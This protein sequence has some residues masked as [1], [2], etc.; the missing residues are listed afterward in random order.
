MSSAEA[1]R[2]ADPEVARLVAG[3][4]LR[5]VF[6]HATVGTV[7]AT[8]FALILASY[9]SANVPRPQL[10]AWVVLKVGVALA[11][12]VFAHLYRLHGRPVGSRWQRWTVALLAL[13]GAVWGLGGAWLMGRDTETVAVVA[14]S[15]TGVASI[16]TFGLQVRLAATAAYVVPMVAPTA[17]ALLARRDEFGLFVGVGLLLFLG[18]MLS[19]ARRS[20]KRLAEVFTLR[21]L[22]D[23]IAAERA[24][25]LALARRQSAVKSQFLATM[26]HEFRT[27]LHGILGLARLTRAEHDDPALQHRL[28]L[29]EHSGE[30]LLRLINDLLDVSRIE[31]GRVE[32]REAAFDLA[33]ELDE[34][35]DVYLVRCDEKGL[36]FTVRTELPAPCWVTG[37]ATR[38]RQVLHN[39]LGNAIKFTQRGEVELHAGR[40]ADGAMVFRV[41][42]SG[43][44][45][46]K[47]DLPHVFDAFWQASEV[48]ATRGAGTGLGLNIALE[49]SRAMGGDIHCDSEL[50]RGTQFE[51]V[52]PLP[53]APA[54]PEPALGA[55][56][57]LD[58]R[59][60]LVRSRV[61]LAEDNDVN[62]LLIEAILT[63]HGCVVTRVSNGADAVRLAMGDGERPDVVLMDSQMPVMDG[64][65]AARRI[66]VL[67]LA[68]GLPRVAIVALTA[69]TADDDRQQCRQAGMDDFVGKPFTEA[70]LLAALAACLPVRRPA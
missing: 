57:A 9:L 56:A 11:R 38:L 4:Q 60:A 24:E 30:H 61:L 7:V 66:R 8:V 25:A 43:S 46:A 35:A 13:D 18:L 42:D 31:S 69:N 28:G 33:A 55:D 63:R 12:V 27:P 19:T 41:K 16:A 21:F 36:A 2:P 32:V 51:L 40:R 37:D 48:Q 39:L 15:L 22:T 50:G 3:E 6:A 45:I 23:R 53:I 52:L 34:L 44:G 1:S 17:L 58:R 59:D 5:M 64:L 68:Q 10:L 67:E 29:I 70:E 47:D 26:S 65:E 62:A 54:P 14:A 20:E 49:I